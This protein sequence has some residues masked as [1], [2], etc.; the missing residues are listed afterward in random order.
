MDVQQRAISTTTPRLVCEDMLGTGLMRRLIERAR[1]DSVVD[2]LVKEVANNFMM[3]SSL[4]EWNSISLLH[5]KADSLQ[6]SAL[7]VSHS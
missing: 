6:N 4:F 7:L 1:G 3:I 2:G 5:F